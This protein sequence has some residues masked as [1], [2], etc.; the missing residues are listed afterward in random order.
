MAEETKPTQT[1]KQT[2][3][4]ETRRVPIAKPLKLK[5]DRRRHPRYEQKLIVK[6]RCITSGRASES[7]LQVGLIG[8]VGAGGVM[9]KSKQA[10]S[11]GTILEIKFPD[12]PPFANKTLNAEVVWLFRPPEADQYHLGCKFVK[13]K[14]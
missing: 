12:S 13:L 1:P 5:G 3:N 7:H 10:Y 9:M 2:V 6:F 14:S 11:T 8:D 4:A